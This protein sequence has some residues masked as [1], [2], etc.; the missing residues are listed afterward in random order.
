MSSELKSYKKLME[1]HFDTLKTKFEV[2]I[3][4]LETRVNAEVDAIFILI[5][6]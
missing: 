1:H 4:S 2:I 6:G 3:A 5:K